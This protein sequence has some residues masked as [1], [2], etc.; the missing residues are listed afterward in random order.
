MIRKKFFLSVKENR[1]FL[2]K[3]R[4]VEELLNYVY[5]LVINFLEIK[6]ED[7]G[8]NYCWRDWEV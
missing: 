4:K 6:E 1:L 2:F 5:F 7:I 8:L 3:Y